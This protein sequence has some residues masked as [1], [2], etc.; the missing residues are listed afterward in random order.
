MAQGKPVFGGDAMIKVFG[1]E[2]VKPELFLKLVQEGPRAKLILVDKH[3][4]KHGA[5]NVLFIS[6]DGI[7][8]MASITED[9]PFKLNDKGEIFKIDE[10]C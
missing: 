10:D 3:G 7:I 8:F 9:A 1:C 4:C 2:V 6:E 5:G